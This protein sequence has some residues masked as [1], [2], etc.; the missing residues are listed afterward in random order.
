MN[1]EQTKLKFLLSK[2]DFIN[3]QPQTPKNEK[4]KKELKDEIINL[5][6][7]SFNKIITNERN[8]QQ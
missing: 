3:H 6:L 7:Q 4:E 1:I 2:L 5:L 8:E